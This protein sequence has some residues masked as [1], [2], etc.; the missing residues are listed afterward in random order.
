L[1][2]AAFILLLPVAVLAGTLDDYYLNAFGLAPA[3]GVTA[4]E[5]A[6]LSPAATTGQAVRSGTPLRHALKRDWKQLE[7]A[8]Q[9]TLARVL[10]PPVLTGTE[11]TLTLPGGHFT[12][13]YTLSGGDAPNVALLNTFNPG[14][15][16]TSI[17]DW[18]AQ[19]A[20]RFEDAYTFYLGNSGLGYHLPPNFPGTPFTVYLI[21]LAPEQVYG[22]TQSGQ[23][24]PSAGFPNAFTSYIEIDKDFTDTLYSPNTFTPLQ[25][26]QVTSVHEFHHAIQYGY[27][28]YF[29]TWYAEA[30][31]TWFEA[32]LYPAVTQL[33][34][35]LPGWFSDTTRRLDLPQTDLNF[36]GEAYG[37]WILNRYMAEK[38]GTAVVRTFWESIA[39]I[40]PPASGD[41]QMA[42][43]LDSVL[44]SS[45]SSTLGNELLG[46]AKRVYTRDWPL[47]TTTTADLN[48][49]PT[50][51]ANGTF[52]TYPVSS[53]ASS[54]VT[55]PHYSFAYY[56]FT[57]STTAANLTITLAKT[58]GIKAALFKK[59]SGAISEIP[60]NADG[61]SYT[62]N[63][64]GSLSP[65]FDEAA[66]LVVNTTNV[67]NHAASFVTDGNVAPVTE[68]GTAPSSS[69]GGKSGCFI[70]TAAYGSYLHPKVAEL[71]DF[72]DRYLMTNV[73]GRLFVALYYR[74]S[75]P[76]A[77]VIAEHEWMRVVVRGALTPVVLA[78][79]HPAQALVVLLLSALGLLRQV[80][81][82]RKRLRRL[83]PLA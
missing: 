35:Y 2:Q 37:R 40:A 72:R 51:T 78:V 19:V 76:V 48:L 16:L 60:V 69:G 33:Y 79:E 64:F 10:N 20:A 15:N 54:S 46:L 70:A 5:K 71:R 68:P 57:P 38:H 6:V 75:P 26:L 67:D 53:S 24:A 31:S 25:S 23:P 9:Q 65:F 14:L 22:F 18:A 82:H 27:N 59:A 32:E 52:S 28:F 45:Y 7:S 56:K 49:I 36:N 21:S 43:V 55:L 50:Y 30:T 77:R 13:H 34:R 44:T 4:L 41:I 12:I 81:T 58:S 73:P 80:R 62:V 61:S 83:I 63:G 74:L 39:G 3:T 11:K 66:L 8:T 42:P 29:D 1:L 17:D 47:P